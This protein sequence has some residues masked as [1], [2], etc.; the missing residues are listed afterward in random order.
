V[1]TDATEPITI[2]FI[3]HAPAATADQA[4][5]YEDAVLPLLADHGARL[6]YRGRRKDARDE[7]QPFEVHVLW[8]PSRDAFDAYLADDRRADLL[9]RFGEVFTS[10]QV[11]ELETVAAATLPR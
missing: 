7:T 10:K 4:A 8:F 2:V 3:G 11:V 5:A 1:T 9:R 6:V